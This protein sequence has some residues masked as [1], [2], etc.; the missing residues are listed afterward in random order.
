[1]DKKDYKSEFEEDRKEINL[2]DRGAKSSITSRAEL[3][4][5]ARKP[6]K[7]SRHSIINIILVLFT[8][9]PVCI[10]IFV[11]SNWYK[12]KGNEE[13]NVDNTTVQFETSKNT[14]SGKLD[15]TD[16]EVDIVDNGNGQPEAGQNIETKPDPVP[17]VLP[18]P[19]P[20][21]EPEP[22]P[23]PEKKPD[24]KPVPKPV[25]KPEKKPVTGA[26]SHTV[27]AGENLYRISLK[28]YKNGDGVDKIKQANGLKSN[29]ITV[30]S[31]LV[32][33]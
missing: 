2:G 19:E 28:Y 3:H 31:K 27:A 18:E 12:P 16:I 22:A 21:P 11:I 23:V 15:K 14:S 5:S 20:E 13:V 24:P 9:I 17:E 1:M 4:R 29:E 32:I 8:L 30:G 7:R 6:Q 33:P 25:P 26:T 10:L